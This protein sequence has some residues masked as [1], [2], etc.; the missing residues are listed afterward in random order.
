[1]SFKCIKIFGICLVFISTAVST[2]F[3]Q[4]LKHEMRGAWLTTVYGLDWPTQPAQSSDVQIA[5]LTSILDDLQRV[6]INT[7]F[8]QI[9]SEA[10]A[11][12]ESPNEPWSR[13]LT[14][15]MGVPPN[16]YYDPLGL[17]IELAHERGMELHAWMNPFRAVSS[18]GPFGL[19]ATHITKTR[20]DWILDVKYKGGDPDLKDE[21][22]QIFN[23][24]ILET[25]DYIAD[26]V[27]DV[28]ARYNVD[29]IHFD[30]YFYPYPSYNITNEDESYYLANPRGHLTLPDW[31]RDNINRFVSTVA[32]KIR[33]TNPNVKFGISPFG[34]WKSGVPQGIVGLSSYDV[35]FADPLTWMAQ[36]TVDYLTPQLYWAFGGAQDFRSLADWWVTQSSGRH[37][38]TGQAVYRVD[39][40]TSSGTRFSASEILLQIDFGRSTTGIQGSV[41]FRASNLRPFSDNLGLTAA[42]SGGFYAQKAFTPF[43][44]YA[45]T[46]SPDQPDNLT[47]TQN[48]SNVF[49]RWDPPLTGFA[50]AN[51]FGVYRLR[52][53][54]EV[55]NP[56]DMTN[57]AANLIAISWEPEYTDTSSLEAGGRYFYAVTGVTPNSVEGVE[58]N[59][60][61]VVAVHTSTENLPDSPFLSVTA[62]PNPASRFVTLEIDLQSPTSLTVDVFDVLGRLVANVS[63][64]TTA[65]TAGTFRLRWDISNSFGGR[66][67][68]GTYFIVAKTDGRSITRPIVVV[69]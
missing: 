27:R 4:N 40:A 45:D 34:I 50:Y 35:I 21:V 59:L 23:P 12:Y 26:V 64:G 19:S 31:R 8:F 57:D 15:T 42:L 10:D 41:H 55:P 28:V 2:A 46:G 9:R 53:D 1:M 22:V 20:P 58:S 44:T 61:N 30:D 49:L 48:A 33:T 47:V 54:T 52:S 39:S 56:Q 7:V 37:I 14:G 18:R 51:K 36:G 60:A 16:P 13:F 11:M 29:G 3:C 67:M 68:P 24:G 63:D 17:A 43:M 32:A 25:H 65:R 6:G 38:Y 5:Q 62:F 69:R 66:L